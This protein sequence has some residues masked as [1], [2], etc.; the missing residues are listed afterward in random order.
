[1]MKCRLV[2]SFSILL[3][4]YWMDI[5]EVLEEEKTSI[6]SYVIETITT[7]EHVLSEEAIQFH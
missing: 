4:L 6:F 3:C 7:H 2:L 5:C 1:M